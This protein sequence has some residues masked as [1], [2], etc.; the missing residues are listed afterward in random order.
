[1]E[2]QFIINYCSEPKERTRLFAQAIHEVGKIREIT[3]DAEST[4]RQR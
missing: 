2:Q 3:L 1:M 4:N